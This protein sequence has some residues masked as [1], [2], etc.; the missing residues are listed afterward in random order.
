ML[1]GCSY[2]TNGPQGG[3]STITPKSKKIVTAVISGDYDLTKKL[4]NNRNKNSFYS[5]D[6]FELIVNTGKG[7]F[8][9]SNNSIKSFIK[10][11]SDSG[12]QLILL[13]S[14]YGHYEIVKLLLN[15]RVLAETWTLGPYK[16]KIYTNALSEAFFHSNFK[17]T[18]LLLQYQANP[19]IFTEKYNT[20]VKEYVNSGKCSKTTNT[21]IPNCYK[22]EIKLK[23]LIN[24]K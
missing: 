5:E 20:S 2:Q 22:E 18:Y 19:N 23:E 3:V 10:D 11:D 14:K 16:S 12:L 6:V 17:I 24:T 4:L 21:I 15:N 13:A 8:A 1:S 7:L 9:L